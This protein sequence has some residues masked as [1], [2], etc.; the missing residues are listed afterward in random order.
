MSD[1]R[2]SRLRS[3]PGGWNHNPVPYTDHRLVSFLNWGPRSWWCWSGIVLYKESFSAKVIELKVS[4]AVQ[5]WGFIIFMGISAELIVL[6]PPRWLGDLL[7]SNLIEFVEDLVNNTAFIV[8]LLTG[9]IVWLITC[10]KTPGKGV[11]FY[12]VVLKY[13]SSSN[14]KENFFS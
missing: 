7:W 13:S 12:F 2:R 14:S 9:F 8:W 6:P 1:D 3:N 10:F 11:E 4:P 5:G